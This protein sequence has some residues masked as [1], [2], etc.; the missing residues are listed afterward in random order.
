MTIQMGVEKTL[1]ELVPGVKKV[2]N[3]A[4]PMA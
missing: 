2:E 3:V 1:K 4:A